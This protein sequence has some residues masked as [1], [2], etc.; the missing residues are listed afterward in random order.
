MVPQQ[1]FNIANTSDITNIDVENAHKLIEYYTGSVENLN[2]EHLQAL[3]DMFTD[4]WFAYGHHKTV[5]YLTRHGVPVFQYFFAYE[6]QFSL[7]NQYV[8]G[9]YGV[10]H[11]DEL[12]YFW[13]PLFTLISDTGRGP[14]TGDDLLMREILLNAWI[15]FATY[16]DPTPPDSGF[17]WVPQTPSTQHIFWY[18]SNL[19]PTM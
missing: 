9:S 6:G 11:T 15:N 2:A 3:V 18:I 14:L 16:G 13:E 7:T 10:C 19:E 4:S 8:N 5:D 1:I 12:T 17:D